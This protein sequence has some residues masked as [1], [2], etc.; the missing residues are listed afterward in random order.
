MDRLSEYL[1]MVDKTARL[2]D[3]AWDPQIRST[4]KCI[5]DSYR[6]LVILKAG[7]FGAPRSP[8]IARSST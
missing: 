2:A 6:E 5:A 1:R 3:D 7:Q 4:W 8:K